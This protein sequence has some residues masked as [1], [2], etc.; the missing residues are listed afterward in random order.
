MYDFS[1]TMEHTQQKE[2]MKKWKEKKRKCMILY[3]MGRPVSAVFLP[4]HQETVFRSEKFPNRPLLTGSQSQPW[5]TLLRRHP[6][7]P[8]PP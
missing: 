2:I 7:P 8:P 4:F 3:Y 5:R 1:F 6:L